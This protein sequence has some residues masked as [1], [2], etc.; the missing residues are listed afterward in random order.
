MF[1]NYFIQYI[2]YVYFL[3]KFRPLKLMLFQLLN[4]DDTDSRTD[5]VF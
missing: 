4:G 5:F 3:I 2:G 1:W